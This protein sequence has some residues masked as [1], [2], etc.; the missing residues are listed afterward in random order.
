MKTLAILILSASTLVACKKSYNCNCTTTDV[1]PAYSNGSNVNTA[2]NTTVY[3][4]TTFIKDT[5]KKATEFC[6]G[7]SSTTTYASPYS[8]YG[9]PNTIRTTECKLQ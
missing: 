8:S 5:K 6:E 4:N 7:N 2:G 3:N 1:E 9:Q